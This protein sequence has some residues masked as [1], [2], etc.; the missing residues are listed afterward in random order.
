MLK[1]I[2]CKRYS[3]VIFFLGL[4]LPS[5]AQ[6]E[7]GAETISLN[8]IQG[9]AIIPG[10]NTT[11]T[12]SNTGEVS[13]KIKNIITFKINEQS[14]T[15]FASSFTAV[16][17]LKI[18]SWAVSNPLSSTVQTQFQ[19]LTLN[20]NG[21]T[22][23]KYDVMS[24]LLLSP[25]EQVR[26]TVDTIN[27]TGN[28]GWDPIRVLKLENE[29]RVTR[30]NNLSNSPAMLAP[31]SLSA[32][33][34]TDALNV[35]WSWN[36]GINNNMS[37]LEWAWLPDEMAGYYA[38][39]DMLFQSNSSRVDLDPGKNNYQIPLLYGDTGK[40]YYR[41][42]AAL[43][44]NDGTVISGPWSA[45]PNFPHNGHQ[46]NLNW[47]SSTSFAEN[48]KFKTVIQYFDG[49]LKTRQT[50]T[51]DNST[52]NI[53]VAETIYDLQ[54]RPNL[55]ILPTPTSGGIIKYF[56][57]FNRFDVTGQINS[58]SNTENP[59]RY[60][61]LS[62]E[63]DKCN[64]SP[65]LD[66]TFGNGKY[67]SS[68]NYWMNIIM[69]VEDNSKY[70][71]NANGYAYS[72]TRYL[73]DATQRVSRQGGVGTSFQMNSGH[74]TKYFYGK[75][76]QHELDALFGTEVGDASHYSKNMVQ[77]ANGQMSVS[78]VDMHGRTIATALAGD[79][80]SNLQPI[81][82]N[83]AD[84]PSNTGAVLTNQLL[85]AATNIIEGNSI[86]SVS[87]ILVPAATIYNFTYKLDPAILSLLN[88]NN[89]QICFDCKYDL[90]ISIRPE[91]CSNATPI[92]RKY[93][94]LGVA[95][96]GN[97]IGFTGPGITVPTKQINFSESLAA[98]SWIVRKTLSINDSIFSIRRDSAQ[99][100]FLCRT[101]Q[102][103]YDSVY[104]SL[105]NSSACY[106][107]GFSTTRPCDSCNANLGS[108]ATYK[109]KYLQAIGIVISVP[110]YD[111]E[112]RAQYTRDSLA[113]AGA[114]GML[115]V[116]LSS[117]KSLR[118]QLL[119]DMTPYS[120]QYAIPKDS[121]KNA[122]TGLFDPKRLEAK[123][124]IFTNT[125]TTNPGNVVTPKPYYY[126]N[127]KSES[128]LNADYFT[129]DDKI[130]LSIEPTGIP[131]DRSLLSIIES[132]EFT[133]RFQRS[134][135][136][137]LVYYH[138]EFSKLK[139]AESNLVSTYAW[140]DNV[141]ACTT[142]TSAQANG[143]LTPHTSDPFF[144]NNYD[145]AAYSD[146]ARYLTS[147]IGLPGETDRPSIWRIANGN[148][149]C[150]TT[151]ETVKQTCINGAL[152]TGMDLS[153][154]RDAVWEQ[155]KSIYLS[156]RNE[157]VLKHINSRPGVLSRADMDSL[158]SQKKQLV[159]ATAQDLANQNGWSWWA[160]ATAANVDTA[161]LRIAA[162]SY[163]NQVSNT[164]KCYGQKPFWK[165]RLLQCEQLQNRL[166]RNTSVDSIAVNNILNVILDSMVMVCRN[167]ASSQQPY[168]NSTVNPA[169]TGIPRGF[170]EVIHR[171]FIQNG[172]A[173][174]ADSNYFCNPW[175]I[176]FPK[177]FG[178]NPPLW[179]NN[180]NMIDTCG[181]A[182]FAALKLEAK[183]LNYD[184]LNLYGTLGMNQF[185]IN[186]YKDSITNFLWQGLQ[187]CNAGLIKDSCY[188]VIAGPGYPYSPQALTVAPNPCPPLIINSVYYLNTNSSVNNIQVNYTTSNT[189]GV[190]SLVIYDSVYTF[191]NQLQIT[192]GTNLSI[193]LS[194]PKCTSYKFQLLATS[195]L[196]NMVSAE[197]P[198]KNPCNGCPLPPSINGITYLNTG[199]VNN[200][201][202]NSLS[203]STSTNCKIVARNLSTG[204]VYT[205]AITCGLSSVVMSLPGCLDYTFQ[206]FTGVPGTGCYDSSSIYLL[207]ACTTVCKR[208]YNPIMLEGYV[209]MP[210]FLSCGYKRPC[211]SCDTLNAL[212]I[213]FKL[214]YPAYNVPYTDTVNTTA[215]QL[216]QNS[217][218][219]R[220]LNYR[221]GFSKNAGEYIAVIKTCSAGG[222][223]DALCAFAKPANDISDMYV[224]D[225]MPCRAV[226][227]QA[228][229]IAQWLF[230]QRRDSVI[231]N[232]DSLYKSKCMGAKYAE[233]FYAT[234]QPK[235]YHYTLYFYDQAGNLVKTMPPA[236]VKPNYSIVYLDSVNNLR[237]I[238]QDKNNYK[239][240]DLLSTHYRYNSLNQVTIQKAPDA[241]IS[242]FWY[243]RLGRLAVSQNAKQQL[244][245]AYSY[246]LYDWL[247]RITE[248]G[249]KPQATAMM[250]YISQDTTAL[251]NWV[252]GTGVKEQITFTKYDESY[253]PIAASTPTSTG[254]WQ[255][256]LRNRV[257][258]TYIKNMD[259]TDPNYPWDAASFYT[260]DI[261]GNVDTLLQ[262]YKT[263]IGSVNCAGN[264][265][266]NRFKKMVYNY[267]LISGKVNDVGYQPGQ[268]DQFYHHYNYDAENRLTEVKTSKDRI[269][270]E[271]DAVYDYY[272]HG[273]LARM[274]L[275]Q[276]MVQGLDYA[277]TLQGWLKGVNSTAL[278]TGITGTSYDMGRDGVSVARN[279]NSLVARDAFGFS[280]NY[281]YGDYQPIKIS[282][283]PF[284]GLPKAPLPADPVSN[285]STGAQLYNG[286][287]R[288]M[289][290]NLRM[291]ADANVYG[292]K[293]DQLNRLVRMDV[294]E[295]LRNSTNSFTPAITRVNNYHEEISY[296][297]NG[298][299]RT[300][301]R[302]G[303]NR[304]LGMDNLTYKY[305]A[306]T[307]QLNQVTDA[308]TAAT[309]VDYLD[310]KTQPL[311][312]YKYDKIGNLVS[313]SA[314][315]ISNIDWTVYGKIKTIT[316]TNG[317]VI[318]YAYDP[319]GN[320]ISKIVTTPGT[321][322]STYYVR[323]ASGN[324]MSVY[325]K[326][327]SA[328]LTQTE[329]HLY[330]S[331]RLGVYN[332]N[333]D[334][335]NCSNTFNPITIFT[336]GI[337]LYELS[338]HLGNVLATIADK[339]TN[340]STD[341]VT[342]AYYTADVITTNDYYPGG[343]QMP[344]RKY[345][346]GGA[347]LYRYGFNG[348]ENDNE[349]KGAGNQQDYGMR[350]YDPRLVRFLSVDPLTRSYPMLTPYQFAS[351]SPIA[352]IDIDGEEFGW[353]VTEYFEKKIFGTTHLQKIR[354]GYLDRA[355]ET[356]TGIGGFFKEAYDQVKNGEFQ[357][358]VLGGID[359]TRGPNIKEF[360]KNADQIKEAGKAIIKDYASLLKE[361][362][363]GNDEAIGALGFEAMLFIVP[364]GEEAKG[365]SII[366][367]GFK[368]T[369]QFLKVGEEFA[370]A[371]QK[372]G[373]KFE[374]IGVKG[375]SVT[376]KSWRTGQPFRWGGRKPSDIDAFV[377]LKE[378][379]PINGGLNRPEFIH[380]AKLLK[381]YPALKEWSDK[382]TKILGR[383]ITPA[384][385]KPPVR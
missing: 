343:M 34:A 4:L 92:I 302:N 98:G 189:Y 273:P 96:C 28:A 360:R 26:V 204:T 338:N 228:T 183:A 221:T 246:T 209:A 236:A 306:N 283:T 126:Q 143:Y 38:N 272:R 127:P 341:G 271:R 363:K 248:V 83:T 217:L 170:E 71:P 274:E 110:F 105:I 303:D 278:L 90:E 223:A 200:V 113:C 366:P 307:N 73:D 12:Y 10:A 22:G 297:P 296:D 121:I 203:S 41:V 97:S 102:S 250:Q 185:F 377:T 63:S 261:H 81:Y 76:S 241:G 23:S 65:R 344:G 224:K 313:D 67:Y 16:V 373:I 13:K 91:D 351:N 323:D 340:V 247:G 40:L 285:I 264:P 75:P 230:Q 149:L 129:E 298:N 89:Q 213:E 77:D 153:L 151:S 318:K 5:I 328:S 256:N 69:D 257:S 237:N 279:N 182:G 152:K 72:E 7:E 384:A 51:K 315:G 104:S 284:V 184:T 345:K 372:S 348:K 50:V 249:Q 150:A 8:F 198:L 287:I 339:K 135:A 322:D 268:P 357:P 255:K 239:N 330:G 165:A 368:S 172:I 281:Y 379:I 95:S 1:G 107:P 117:L 383:D 375:S 134:W 109:T 139:Y 32:V 300:Y 131:N 99:T 19:S 120:G 166:N 252:N 115:N 167:S 196:C 356:I 305:N 320:R 18:E 333:L 211:I 24:Y 142:Y 53:V 87:A 84:Y 158:Q 101:E 212:V 106:T 20:Y 286:N 316:K 145:A 57:D 191:L 193:T 210:A 309:P 171:V 234:Y 36:A 154:N 262:D 352:G 319:D 288:A 3:L 235:E 312:N 362:A 190:C 367:R 385:I 258:Y 374:E 128:G 178:K 130:D 347:G 321:G 31:V 80:T 355:K 39:T 253:T 85:T 358:P 310:V 147:N 308:V 334:V 199:S 29:M 349:V 157:M 225:T 208:Q 124:N 78:Y 293:Y 294:F 60:F 33:D 202:I 79:S 220:F 244:V 30:Y 259:G 365:V 141:Q 144:V 325:N 229:F 206:V 311:N 146:M 179:T 214:K 86:Q 136:K 240:N 93:S 326:N 187:K 56:R 21:A 194:L 163:L 292:Y 175:T 42:R 201:R 155:F 295:N 314:E 156:Y 62:L 169:Y 123:F 64:A 111:T 112:I 381:K 222:S 231:A 9:S 277:Y 226:Q 14:N 58:P 186:R 195:A 27:I 15:F 100:A 148:I 45:S 116:N 245:N 162:A 47:Q 324:E 103:I 282:A 342:V 70:I 176:D 263:G 46:T 327:G 133:R 66:T 232:F 192:C 25:A 132:D 61:D 174:I 37:H 49:S 332:V 266:G 48:G 108:F 382:W 52:G 173:T 369:E 168:G 265:S 216:K 11:I 299:I 177:P 122:A 94:N 238:N 301:L 55:Q 317:T 68:N 337:K 215:S 74:E 346:I 119:E 188:S 125:Y 243:D 2:T 329:L 354:K 35:S 267:D 370:I 159:F 269:Y 82:T 160:Q 290:V 378:D 205:Q 270:W 140:L 6:F 54:G 280:L 44:K 260:Y 254:L 361:A 364:G 233:Q 242:K 138:P 43:R 161:A 251:K 59:A 376:G 114:C 289:V 181:C 207:P 275:G 164:D 118:N 371:L 219:A 227:T 350:I 336:R 380:P 304:S 359:P 353:F 180:T 291:L 218:L 17:Y 137:S 276:N 197:I 88:C 335:Q 331:S